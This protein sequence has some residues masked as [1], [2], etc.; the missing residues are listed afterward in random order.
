MASPS[1]MPQFVCGLGSGFGEKRL[2]SEE[3]CGSLMAREDHWGSV[4]DRL[5]SCANGWIR[6]G[7]KVLLCFYS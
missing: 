7:A 2:R 1:K 5:F 6:L 4:L 3:D